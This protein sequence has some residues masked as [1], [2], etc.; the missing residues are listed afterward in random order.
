[1]G[2]P[3]RVD[4]GGYV[5]HVVNRANARMTIFDDEA[6]YAA[7]ERIML[8]AQERTNMRLLAW[9]VLPNHWHMI[10]Q[11]RKDGDLARFFGWLTLTHTQRWHAHQHSIGQGH[12][13]QGRYKS[14]LVDAEDY[15]LSA[16]RYV[17]RNA[18]RAGLVTPGEISGG[19]GGSRRTSGGGGASGRASGGAE[20][21]RWGSLWR[22]VNRRKKLVDVPTLSDWPMDRPRNWV[23]RVNQPQSQEELDALRLCMQR[24]R[25]YGSAA[26]VG[27]MT[28][29]FDLTATLNPRGRPKTSEL[30]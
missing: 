25:P 5:Y 29:K 12:L 13:Y 16:C 15:F 17:E 4:V 26:W 11:P 28:T 18:L 6:D 22:W 7:F 27:R 14:F 19:R 10:V 8:E 30:S 9:C 2:R 24:G 1:M 23:Q 21:W 3:L 20:D